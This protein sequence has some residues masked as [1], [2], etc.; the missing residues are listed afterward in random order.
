[1]MEKMPLYLGREGKQRRIIISHKFSLTFDIEWYSL[2]T[3][4]SDIE[5]FQTFLQLHT[6]I[7]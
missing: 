2:M 4:D 7:H 6:A 1:M 5:A 3:H